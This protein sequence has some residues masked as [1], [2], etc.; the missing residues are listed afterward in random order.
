MTGETMEL[1][2]VPAAPRVQLQGV[3]LFH[4]DVCL[5]FFC[6]FISIETC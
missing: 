6:L 4:T 3:K 2:F 1:L 5:C